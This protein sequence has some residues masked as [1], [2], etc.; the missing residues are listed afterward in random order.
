MHQTEK[1]RMAGGRWSA[2]SLLTLAVAAAGVVLGG[3]AA[4]RGECEPRWL[5]GDSIPGVNGD[6]CAVTTWDPDGAGPAGELLVVGGEFTFAGEVAANRIAAWDGS[7]WQ[8]LGTG[9]GGTDYAYVNALTVYNG[10]LIARGYFASAG[11]QVSAFIARWGLPRGD[12]NGDDAIDAA[13]LELFVAVLLGLDPDE[14]RATAA[15]L[16]RSGTADGLDIQ[17]FVNALLGG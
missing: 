1:A 8:P 13:D 4:A 16:D 5:P 12:L 11:G 10:E 7:Q 17:P 3:P 14:C 6:V 9:T 2:R 15:D